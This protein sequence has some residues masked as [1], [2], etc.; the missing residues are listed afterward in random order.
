MAGIVSGTG[1]VL[2][3]LKSHVVARVWVSIYLGDLLGSGC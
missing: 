2:L 3:L 1:D